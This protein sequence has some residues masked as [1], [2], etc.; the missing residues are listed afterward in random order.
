[1]DLDFINI[2]ISGYNKGEN[3]MSQYY[4]RKWK[5]AEIEHYTKNEFFNECRNVLLRM[6]KDIVDW[7]NEEKRP[8]RL[9]Y[10]ELISGKTKPQEGKTKN[11]EIEEDLYWIAFYSNKN[12]VAVNLSHF[13][14][15]R[16]SGEIW[17]TDIE[18]IRE[19]LKEA[20]QMDELQQIDKPQQLPKL[21]SIEQT[22][23]LYNNLIKGGLMPKETPLDDFKYWFGVNDKP[24]DLKPL[25]WLKTK[26]LLAYFIQRQFCKEVTDEFPDKAACCAF[27][28]KGLRQLQQQYSGNK[29]NSGKPK[30]FECIDCLFK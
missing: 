24:K 26:A 12:S 11:E 29:K 25:K 9:H 28:V 19:K 15:N 2:V 13:T 7:L 6:E 22:E 30:G 8:F 17:Y 4:H 27:G 18:N 21:L 3:L 14:N 23:L 10:S 20:E 1:M 16:C 5:D